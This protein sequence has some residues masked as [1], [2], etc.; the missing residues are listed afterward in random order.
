MELVQ[1]VKSC[2]VTDSLIVADVF[3]KE[4]KNIVRDI[5]TIIKTDG[6]ILS[7]QM[8]IE[9][10]YKS[11]GKNYIKYIISQ[12]GWMLLTMGFT[13]KLALS[14]K[15]EFIE[16]FNKMREQLKSRQV[17]RLE[18]PDM[19]NALREAREEEGKETKFFHYANEN[20]LVYR[21]VFGRDCK[22]I[23][24]LLGVSDDSLRDNLTVIQIKAVEHI[25][26]L[27]T[28]LIELGFEYSERKEK[29]NKVFNKKY[30]Q[31]MIDEF[32]R[33]EA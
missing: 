13:G 33:L 20:N 26:K 29:L 1:V 16:A 31:A 14:F 5:K 4:H 3:N 23:K 22:T 7:R 32:H 9:S 11:R 15:L 27:N 25:Q 24:K 10:T 30:A 17:A 18:N 8:F 6:S 19:T 12:D 21:V 2:V 28:S